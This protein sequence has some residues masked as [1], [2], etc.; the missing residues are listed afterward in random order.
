MNK[1]LKFTYSFSAVGITAFVSAFFSAKAMQTFYPDL[2]MPMFSAPNAV[3]APVW[4][5]LYTLM[6]VS[7]YMILN[8]VDVIKVQSANL[9]FF[10]QLF[11]QM[12]WSY[13]FFGMAFY[14]SAMVVIVL[15]I[16]TVYKM[17][18]QFKSIDKTAGNL[19]YPYL[20]W[21]IYAAYLNAG[22]AYLNVN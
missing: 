21:L 17:I 6:I 14:T 8:S 13:L 12:L 15:M 18:E 5:V 9:L 1:I 3:F 2:N 16:W 20:I 22:I 4:S 10:G 7:Y 11:L 19:Q